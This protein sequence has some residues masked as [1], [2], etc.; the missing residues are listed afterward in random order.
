VKSVENPS[1]MRKNSTGIISFHEVVAGRTRAIIL[2]YDT[3]FV[4]D[5]FMLREVMYV[6]CLSRM[7]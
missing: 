1:L 5:R 7:R 2:Y 4:T 3:C 6:S